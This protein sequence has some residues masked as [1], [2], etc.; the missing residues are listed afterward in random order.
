MIDNDLKTSAKWSKRVFADVFSP[1]IASKHQQNSQN[2]NLLM[3]LARK[4]LQN[5]SKDSVK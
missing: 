1:K 3:F 2:M 5:I 4:P